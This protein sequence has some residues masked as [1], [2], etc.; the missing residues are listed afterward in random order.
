MTECAARKFT[1]ALLNMTDSGHP[2][3]VFSKHLKVL[4][5]SSLR[6]Y[7]NSFQNQVFFVNADMIVIHAVLS[8]EYKI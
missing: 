8:Y 3:S 7:T 2:G 4:P 1:V 5:A 6:E